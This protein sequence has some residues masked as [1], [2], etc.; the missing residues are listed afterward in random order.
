MRDSFTRA[1]D[2]DRALVAQES[3]RAH[4]EGGSTLA[5]YDER[6]RAVRRART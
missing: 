4:A 6:S 1:A 3:G 5:E 2:N